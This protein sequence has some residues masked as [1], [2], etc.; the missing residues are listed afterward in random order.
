MLDFLI[1]HPPFDAFDES[2]LESVAAC[3]E[4]EYFAAGTTIFAQGDEP[5]EHL[6]V[7]R[8]GAVEIV[9][10]GRVLDLRVPG[11]VFGHAST[12]S[13]LPPGFAARAL[14]DTLCY[15]IPERVARDPLARPESVEFA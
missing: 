1:A 15:R 13:G 8:S 3:A 14:E 2:E 11:E 12:L 5:I 4:V 10:A 6:R 9:L 7:V